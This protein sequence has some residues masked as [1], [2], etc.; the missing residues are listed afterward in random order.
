MK[1]EDMRYMCSL[2]DKES[3]KILIGGINHYISFVPERVLDEIRQG[4]PVILT[5][6]YV[7]NE[8]I[9][10]G[11][12]YDGNEI[13]KQSLPFTEQIIL[14]HNQ[15]NLTI[16]LTDSRYN[17]IIK[18]EYMYMLENLDKSWAPLDI[19]NNQITYTNLHPG[20]YNLIIRQTDDSGRAIA[21]RELSIQISSPWYS[22]LLAKLIYIMLI[23]WFSIWTINYFRV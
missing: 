20:K 18:A 7:N 19:T 14:N 22:T 17:Q 8:P 4:Q 21:I 2:L 15:N 23:G 13:L 1:M 12:E 9:C 11:M 10:T 16:Q 3:G 5:T 6:L